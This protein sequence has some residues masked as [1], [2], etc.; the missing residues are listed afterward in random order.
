VGLLRAVASLPMA[1]LNGTVWVAERVLQQAERQ[2]Y[3]PELI[4]RHLEEVDEARVAGVVS[5]EEAD[6]IEDELV[7]RLMESR[8]RTE[9]EV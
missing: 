6:E 3:D 9:R 5:D 1:P 2:H 7:A 8:R 4:R